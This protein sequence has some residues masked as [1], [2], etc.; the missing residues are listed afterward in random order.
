MQAQRF[1]ERFASPPSSAWA[2]RPTAASARSV[3]ARFGRLSKWAQ[4]RGRRCLRSGWVLGVQVET[5]EQPGLQRASTVAAE[6]RKVEGVAGLGLA[7]VTVLDP[8]GRKA[9]FSVG[10]TKNTNT[11]QPVRQSRRAAT[12]AAAQSSAPRSASGLPA[13]VGASSAP[14]PSV[15]GTSRKRAAPYVER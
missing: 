2:V 11:K 14:N 4:P 15:K 8:R 7:K 3:A 13:S 10:L 9:A 6:S 12:V 1:I 5:A